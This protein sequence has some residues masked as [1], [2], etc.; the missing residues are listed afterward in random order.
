M[1]EIIETKDG[2]QTLYR[3]DIDE[4]YHSRAGAVG[5]SRHVFIKEGLAQI[6][7]N[8]VNVLEIGFGTGLNALC[9]QEFLSS[10]PTKKVFYHTLEPFVLP[11]DIYSK[12]RYCGNFS[13][14]EAESFFYNIHQ[15]V[16]DESTEITANFKLLKSETTFQ[17]IDL[18]SE[19]YDL[20]LFDAFAPQKQSE[21]WDISVLHKCYDALSIGGILVTYCA[22]GQFRRDLMQVGFTVERLEGPPGKR[23]MIRGIK[24]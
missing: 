6:T 12:L 14:N 13:F 23:E 21:M 17:L 15:S 7:K 22:Q 24:K 8:E 4:T 3:A 18:K 2:S 1:V 16:W 20:L 10:N 5:E 9:V 11:E 19:F